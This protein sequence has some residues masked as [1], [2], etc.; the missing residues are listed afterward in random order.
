MFLGWESGQRPL[1]RDQAGNRSAR[2]AGRSH[3]RYDV[4][5]LSPLTPHVS[6]EPDA[7]CA[8]HDGLDL[9]PGYGRRAVRDQALP[10]SWRVVAPIRVT[11]LLGQPGQILHLESPIT[12]DAGTRLRL[13]AV[14]RSIYCDGQTHEVTDL[15]LC[16]L[17]GRLQ[18][19]C[20]EAT[21]TL[22]DDHATHMGDVEA[23]MTDEGILLGDLSDWMASERGRGRAPSVP[24]T[25]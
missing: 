3:T 9:L 2:S 1:R 5:A 24:P 21:D 25:G 4:I 22:L 20:L 7:Q 10:R 8:E 17:A 14:R 15:R 11:L 13:D 23:I 16:V 6:T 19:T 12:L 18:G